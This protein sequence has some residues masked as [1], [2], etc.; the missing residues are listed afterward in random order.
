M[1]LIG[2]V[3]MQKKHGKILFVTEKGTGKVAGDTCD[4]IFLLRI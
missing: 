1:K 2:F 4:K 3:E